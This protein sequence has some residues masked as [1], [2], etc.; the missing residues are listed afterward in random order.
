MSRFVT[1]KT[2]FFVLGICLFITQLSLTYS[3]SHTSQIRPKGYISSPVNTPYGIVFTDEHHSC[4]Y[5]E[6]N[7]SVTKLFSAPGC[8]RYMSFSKDGKLIG[9]KYI[10]ASTDLQCPAVYDLVKGTMTKFETPTK[11]A[12]QVS[13][14]DN[15]A[16][17][18][19]YEN[20]AVIINNG[21]RKVIALGTYS[22]RAPI[23][24]DGNKLL[25]RDAQEQLWLLDIASGSKKT[26]TDS[27]DGYANAVWSPDSKSVAYTNDGLKIFTTDLTTNSTYYVADG[28]DVSWLNNSTQIIFVKKDI[29]F[30]KEQ[31][32]NAD[33]YVAGSKGEFV[34]NLS[35]TSNVIELEP[36]YNALTNSIVYQT[37][38]SREIQSIHL[39]SAL[40][41]SA[42]V[43]LYKQTSPLTVEYF[44]SERALL[45]KKPADSL[46][47]YVHIHQVLDSREDW[48]EGSSCCGA[49][50]CV[51]ALASYGILAKWPFTTHGHISNYGLYLSDPYTYRGY[52]FTGYTGWPSGAHGYM[53]NDDGSPYS[54]AV[55]FLTKHG[56][57]SERTDNVS[58]DLILSELGQS[59]P[60]IVCSVGLTAA[61][62][63]MIVG[64]YGTG[65][66][67]YVNDP[68]GDKNAGNYGGI[69]NG[70]N[71]IY[72]W[73]DVNTGH[74]K[75]TPVAWGITAHCRPNA[76]PVV[77]SY[78]PADKADSVK[79]VDTISV[80]FGQI[81]DR[82]STE[83]GFSITPSI[84]GKIVWLNNDAALKF[85]P[86]SPFAKLTKYTVKIDTS[87]KNL[88]NKSF[89][90]PLVFSFTTRLRDHLSIAS[91]Y[92]AA[93][94]TNISTTCQFKLQF[95]APMTMAGLM[96]NVELYNANNE[97]QTLAS[98]KINTADKSIVTFEAKN[99]LTNNA[100]YY[101]LLNGKAY[102]AEGIQMGATVKIPFVTECDK[103][104]S[105]TV[106]DNLESIAGW[107]L[108]KTAESNIDTIAS[109][110][111]LASDRKISG[112]SSAKLNYAFNSSNGICKVT[113]GQ[114]PNITGISCDFAI[115]V[116][117]DNSGNALEYLFNANGIDVEVVA[118]TLNWTG[119]K[120]IKLPVK[121]ISCAGGIEYFTGLAVKQLANGAKTGS[122][123]FD[124]V[125]YNVVV[126]GAPQKSTLQSMN[127]ALYQNYPNPFNPS[128]SIQ[129]EIGIAGHVTLKVYDVLGREIATLVNEEKAKGRYTVEFNKTVASGI[130]YYTL[131]A[132]DYTQTRKMVIMK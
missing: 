62:I 114:K 87:A 39:T 27:K 47:D 45:S 48:G 121:S 82:T 123:Y 54:N 98:V 130:Y 46:P 110:F 106:I 89:E 69:L 5:K 74:E 31:L 79:T 24:P 88:F 35:N 44:T 37:Y 96:G 100:G 8:G 126:T 55:S 105:G 109:T 64:H 85:I 128:T 80:V 16:I 51:Q 67:V 30:K 41:K 65:H 73:S 86:S 38:G 19:T 84:A 15:G 104:Q 42:P 11:N 116:F 29:D 59:Y 92:P 119:W 43:V 75:V 93:N 95:D 66:T 57:Y 129:Y 103:Y 125:Q 76:I 34:D 97:K 22:N 127:Y 17:A 23:S 60:Y 25:Y 36:V 77:S 113:D 63:V 132:G 115:W 53:W 112:S 107:S 58:F 61:H 131:K 32:L 117:G 83:A 111:V 68:Y 52:T 94:Q 102:D 3:Q 49:T 9:F 7:G 13:F 21:Q 50:S 26:I 4:V 78:Y 120:I 14:S 122:V 6:I 118:D 1:K 81:M 18:Y 2:I 12:G 72:D 28:E 70:K 20:N 56:V 108:V 71:A 10:D 90:K 99:A 91:T 124:D 101:F 40:Q 33:I